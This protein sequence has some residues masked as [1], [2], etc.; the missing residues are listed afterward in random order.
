MLT[1]ANIINPVQNISITTTYQHLIQLTI[2]IRN[3]YFH[4]AVGGQRNIRGVEIVENDVFFQLL[5]EE[6]AKWFAS[7]YF[8]ILKH[9]LEQG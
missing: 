5:N 2:D 3:W 1:D 4:F 9:K 8:E 6:I 7:I